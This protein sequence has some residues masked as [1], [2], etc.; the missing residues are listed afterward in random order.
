MTHEIDWDAINKMSDELN[1][2]GVMEP[3]FKWDHKWR[4]VRKAVR[5]ELC[6]QM[7][8]PG[9]RALE[10]LGETPAFQS[11]PKAHKAC[12]LDRYEWAIVK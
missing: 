8:K 12:A 4:T 5:C 11:G 9:E 6:N 10:S 3:A 1:K 7:I 2:P